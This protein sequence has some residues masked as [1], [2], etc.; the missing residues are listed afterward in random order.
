MSEGIPFGRYRLMY[1][2]GEGGMAKVY[3]AVLSGPMGF[4][5]DVALKRLDPRLTAD[6]RMVRSLVNEARLGVRACMRVV[7]RLT[8]PLG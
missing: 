8:S 7:P 4:E 5:K 1:L 2:L 6:E 3:R